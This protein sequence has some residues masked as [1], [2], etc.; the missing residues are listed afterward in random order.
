M[1]SER[2][3]DVCGTNDLKSMSRCETHYRCDDCGTA[4]NLCT[5]CEG[6][7]CESCHGVRVQQRIEN[8]RGDT[9]YTDEIVCPHC[10]HQ[11]SDSSERGEGP[12]EC[13]DCGSAFEVTKYVDVT[14]ST[15]VSG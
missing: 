15:K 5:H 9:D 8:F 1:L 13:D 14:Y 2:H 4:E 12:C 7:L 6:V 10:G 11:H 3:C